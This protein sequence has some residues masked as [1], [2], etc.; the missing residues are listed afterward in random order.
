MSIYSGDQRRGRKNQFDSSEE[1]NQRGHQNQ[2]RDPLTT[3]D[4]A[5]PYLLS[6][7][8]RMLEERAHAVMFLGE[9]A[10]LKEYSIPL[11]NATYR[12]DA[13]SV[14]AAEITRHLEAMNLPSRS[15]YRGE[16]RVPVYDTRDVDSPEIGEKAAGILDSVLEIVEGLSTDEI[17]EMC[18][19][20]SAVRSANFNQQIDLSPNIFPNS[21]KHLKNRIHK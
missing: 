2:R 3:V 18:R 15:V 13:Y 5:L 1:R 12:R 16:H 17:V 14:Y 4:K 8:D 10:A 20:V 7:S 9:F 6:N 21:L 11:T 19:Q